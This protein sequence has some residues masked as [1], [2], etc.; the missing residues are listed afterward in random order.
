MIDFLG[1]LANWGPC[2]FFVD[3]NSNG[4][5]DF[6]ELAEGTAQD[7]NLNAVLDE[8]DIADGTSSDFN[9]NGVPDEC[10]LTNDDCA[11]AVTVADGSTVFDT[12]TATAS[13]PSSDC[14]Q[15]LDDVW[16]R[17][18]ATCLGY[19]TFSLCNAADFDTFMAVYSGSGCP[20][21]FFPAGCS[22]DADG[23][24][25]TSQVTVLV[26]P[27]NEYVIRV[28]SLGEPAQGSATLTISCAPLAA[29]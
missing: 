9:G 11:D 2:H 29:P 19:A 28:G 3:C 18:T 27:G 26:I 5:H 6:L 10:D 15:P 7:C 21:S 25:L 14:G 13:F 23:C 24:G 1:L 20:P 4:V 22:D 8:C 16:F 17:Y 12:Y